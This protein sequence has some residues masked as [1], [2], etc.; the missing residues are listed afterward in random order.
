MKP[1]MTKPA[2]SK[3]KSILLAQEAL[4]RES[5]INERRLPLLFQPAVDGL[6]L[7]GWAK[8]NRELIELLAFQP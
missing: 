1:D 8:A 7:T 5:F 3:R 2:D 6:S 4:V